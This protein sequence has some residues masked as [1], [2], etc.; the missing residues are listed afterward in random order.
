MPPAPPAGEA[1]D[2][3]AALLQ[4]QLDAARAQLAGTEAALATANDQLLARSGLAALVL[5]RPRASPARHG[6][7]HSPAGQGAADGP[8]AAG[9]PAAAGAGAGAP[10]VFPLAPSPAADDGAGDDDFLAAYDDEGAS[11]AGG[12]WAPAWYR[13]GRLHGRPHAAGPRGYRGGTDLAVDKFDS[14]KRPAA[15]DYL[16]SFSIPHDVRRA[17]GL[18]V[19]FK[20]VDNVHATDSAVGSRDEHEARHWYQLLAWLQQLHNDALRIQNTAELTLPQYGAFADYVSVS[21]RRIFAIGAARYDYLSMRQNEPSLAEAYPHADAIPRNGRRGEGARRFLAGVVRQ[22]AYASAKL[23]ALERGFNYGG[24]RGGRGAPG[25]GGG[26]SNS[27]SPRNPGGGGGA[28]PA[29]GGRGGG[30]VER[31]GRGRGRGR[32]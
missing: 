25:G 6:G 9:Q 28:R 21:S 16:R 27:G 17:D 23:G 32:A 11:S 4:E 2:N 30:A 26:G 15:G 13:D 3:A 20:P 5:A 18:P 24:G 19:P 22:E 10:A 14:G 8:P 1:A 12:E 7:L 31:G 29:A